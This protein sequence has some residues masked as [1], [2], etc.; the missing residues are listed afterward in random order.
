MFL[1]MKGQLSIILQVLLGISALLFGRRLFWLFVSV[2]GFIAG[3]LVAE[4]VFQGDSA[5]IVLIFAAACGVL[6]ALLAVLL[7]RF[8]I[9]MSGFL[10]GGYVAVV[11]L[12]HLGWNKD[13]H[14]WIPFLVG[15]F[16]GA[17]LLSI[18]FDPALIFLSSLT[19][20]ILIV[21]PLHMTPFKTALTFLLL[22][23]AGIIIQTTMLRKGPL[24]R[25]K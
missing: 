13:V 8:S 4:L 2:V 1:I 10:A 15:G 3:A 21:Q 11:M 5:W 22:A 25:S 6:G 19:G 24:K 7:Q 20:A 18:I 12:H 14:F 16:L 17:A 23:T 9:A